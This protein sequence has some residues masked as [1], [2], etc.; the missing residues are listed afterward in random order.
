M[1]GGECRKRVVARVVPTHNQPAQPK[2]VS[3]IAE[4]FTM[5]I[6]DA[7]A[8]EVPAESPRHSKRGW[9]QSAETSAA[10]TVAWTEGEDA[11]TLIP[12][13]PRV[14]RLRGRR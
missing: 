7:V 4:V 5:T 11:R 6:I 8:V 13:P 10:F 9:C 3:D 1:P 14:K 12:T 2:T